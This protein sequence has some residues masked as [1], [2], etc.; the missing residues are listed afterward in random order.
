MGIRNSI[1]SFYS[2]G[3][4]R[5]RKN[6]LILVEYMNLKDRK[7][8]WIDCKLTQNEEKVAQSFFMEHYGKKIPLYW[9]R[10]YKN[11][12]GIFDYRYFPEILFSTKLEEVLN[13]YDVAFPLGNKAMNPQSIFANTNLLENGVMVTCPEMI[14]TCCHG[15]YWNNEGDVIREED[16]ISILKQYSRLI[17][18]PTIETMGGRGVQLLEFSKM[19]EEEILKE[20]KSYHGDFIVQ[21]QVINHPSINKLNPSSIN[22]FRVITFVTENDGV[23]VAPLSMRIGINGRIV[24]NGGV[25]I[26]VS[27]DGDLSN[28]GYSKKGI[29]KFTSHPDTGIEFA[30]YHVEGVPKILYAAKKMHSK[31]PQLG[32]LSWDLAYNENGEVVIIEVNTTGQSV[33]FPQ[34][35]SGKAIFGKYTAEMLRKIR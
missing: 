10:M 20:I 29:K 4:K 17:I 15:I 22:T 11:Y 23:Q 26:A 33:W 12:T 32:M 8:E 28:T 6:N 24:D 25:F 19:S 27:E 31:F 30:G 21:K 14:C 3:L 13:P 1:K 16:A 5:F 34:M 35:V 9:H 18:K 2:G 7:S